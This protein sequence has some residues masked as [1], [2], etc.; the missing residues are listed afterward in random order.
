M[1]FRVVLVLATLGP[2]ALDRFFASGRSGGLAM[3]ERGFETLARDAST[4]LGV[5]PQGLHLAGASLAAIGAG[6]WVISRNGKLSATITFGPRLF[7]GG[8]GLGI[9]IRW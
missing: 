6:A 4:S 9:S 5:R 7:G 8:G 2:G 3:R 1:L